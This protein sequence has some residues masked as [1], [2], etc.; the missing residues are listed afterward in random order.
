M[1]FQWQV[2]TCF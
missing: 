1:K 2:V